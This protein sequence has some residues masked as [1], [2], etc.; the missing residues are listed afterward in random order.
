MAGWR[1][2]VGA[3]LVFAVACGGSEPVVQ[4]SP[5]FEAATGSEIRGMHG[6][7][8][9]AGTLG[10]I[11]ARKIDSAMQAKLRKLTRCF[12]IGMDDVPFVGGNIKLSFRV[13]NAGDIE[14][15]FPLQSTIGHRGTEQC[16]LAEAA[17]TR[18]P[19]PR[20][21]TGAEFT[22]PFGMDP[23]GDVRLPVAWGPERVTDVLASD[24]ALRACPGSHDVTIYVAPGGKVMAVGVASD[25][26]EAARGADCVV[27]AIMQL[28]MPDP[29]SYAAKVSFPVD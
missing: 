23:P 10:T 26:A 20:G 12:M 6:G 1:F 11:P 2:R 16:I 28:S 17:R 18:F 3:L 22:W 8:T 27:E 19:K 29:G 25:S 7:V 13:N 5:D 21:G 9:V 24:P 4:E 14:W 15:V